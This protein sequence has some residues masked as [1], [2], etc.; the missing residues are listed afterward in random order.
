MRCRAA[1][2]C[3]LSVVLP[4]AALS[5]CVSSAAPP[6]PSST[7]LI[8]RSSAG[9]P[10][11]PAPSTPPPFDRTAHSTT[12]PTSIWV[13][14]NKTHPITPQDFEPETALVRGYRVATAAAAPL[15]ELLEAAAAQGLDLKIASAFRSF[16]YQ[17]GVHAHLVATG[18]AAFADRVSARAGYSEHQTGL[19]VDLQYVGT[20]DCALDQCFAQTP[21]GTWLAAHSWEYGFIVRY[22]AV[23]QQVTGY[24][25]EPWH[26]RYVGADLA[27]ELHDT[28]VDTLEEFF[29]VTGGDYPSP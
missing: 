16:D 13:V 25:P 6:A 29:G 8:E 9:S 21:A 22:T 3:L 1:T 12:D 2:A 27:R 11:S 19:A 7:A 24:A 18:G 26:F 4:V 23:N 28:G 5:A 14:V 15:E 20:G 17:Q 10:A